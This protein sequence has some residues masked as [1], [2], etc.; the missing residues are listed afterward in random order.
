MTRHGAGRRSAAPS[1]T[2]RPWR[3][4]LRFSALLLFSAPAFAQGGNPAA[5]SRAALDG[6]LA[7]LKAA[8]DESSA[9]LLEQ[10]IRQRWLDQASPA[11]KLLLARAQRDLASNATDEAFDDYEAALDLQPDLTE[12]WL[13]RA[14]VRFRLGDPAGAARDIEQVLRREPSHFGALQDLSR[15][16]ESRGDWRGALAAWQKVLD[17]DPKTPGAQTR[18]ADLR[19]RAFGQAM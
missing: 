19:R 4:V 1:A 10:G 15:M 16:A 8:P 7:A 3:K 14:Q 13:G 2:V 18:L 12:A 9:A 6:M 11:V 5:Q 17:L